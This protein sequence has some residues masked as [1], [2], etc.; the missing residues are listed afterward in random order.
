MLKDLI[1][2]ENHFPKD[3]ILICLRLKIHDLLGNPDDVRESL[4]S[5]K[6]YN[7]DCGYSIYVKYSAHHD[8]IRYISTT[9][10]NYKVP[11]KLK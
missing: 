4:Y 10:S 5:E 9:T 3:L 1:D 6:W 8:G 2:I 11:L 7:L